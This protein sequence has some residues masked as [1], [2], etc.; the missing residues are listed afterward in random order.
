MGAAFNNKSLLARLGEACTAFRTQEGHVPPAF[1]GSLPV[2]MLGAGRLTHLPSWQGHA[3]PDCCIASTCLLAVGRGR[4][5]LPGCIEDLAAPLASQGTRRWVPYRERV[6]RLR[7]LG[8]WSE[9]PKVGAC[10]CPRGTLLH[11]CRPGRAVG[12]AFAPVFTRPCPGG[13]Q[14]ST[15]HFRRASAQSLSES[16]R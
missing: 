6:L 3:S 2:S 9:A 4:A 13:P 5:L 12:S 7:T 10:L 1:C 15:A 16:R 11:A 8:R 14:H